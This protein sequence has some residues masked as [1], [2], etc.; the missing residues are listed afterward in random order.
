M[1]RRAVVTGL[2]AS[3]AVGLSTAALGSVPTPYDWSASPP[4]DD[5]QGFID[6]MVKNRGE[7]PAIWASA[8]TAS[9]NWSRT[10]MCGTIAPSAP[11]CWCR[12]SGS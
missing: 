9:C 2:A 5:R 8:S 12:G 11:T 7:I 4:F 6:W 10:M 3:A 1:H